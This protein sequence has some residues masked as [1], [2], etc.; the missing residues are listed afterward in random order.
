MQ[1]LVSEPPIALVMKPQEK[2]YLYHNQLPLPCD[3]PEEFRQQ[4]PASSEDSGFSERLK[5]KSVLQLPYKLEF[6]GS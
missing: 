5:K 3:L 1:F 4:A 6:G 2:G